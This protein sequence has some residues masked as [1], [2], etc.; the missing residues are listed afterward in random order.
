MVDKYTKHP[1]L[2]MLPMKVGT[3]GRWQ[4]YVGCQ[5]KLVRVT[6]VKYQQCD[7]R[8]DDNLQQ[9][10]SMTSFEVLAIFLL[11]PLREVMFSLSLLFL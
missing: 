11:I 3:R 7:R 5:R 10:L 8:A 2:K 6:N 9:V 4:V 1:I